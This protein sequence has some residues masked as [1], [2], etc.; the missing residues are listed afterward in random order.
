LLGVVVASAWLVGCF[1][2][3][4]DSSGG[5]YGYASSSGGSSG[6]TSSSG[7]NKQPMLV[8][9]DPNQT[10]SA[11][12][13]DGVGVFIEYKTGGHW[14]VWWTCDTNQTAL[15]CDFDV[16]ASVA[17]GSIANPA[18]QLGDRSDAVTQADAQ[19]V[20]A[21]TNT[22]TTA[23]GITFDTVVPSGTTPVITLTATINGTADPEFLFFVQKGEVNGGFPA[24]RLTDPLMLEPSI[25]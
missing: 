24:S 21:T 1:D 11:N 6:T 10:L 20:E 3:T 25:P 5:G 18:G 16:K 15:S 2:G 4:S 9:V 19:D 12:P 22:T 17:T 23:D 8:D 13:G 7:G 14:R